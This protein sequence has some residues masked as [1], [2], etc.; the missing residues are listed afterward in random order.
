[1]VVLVIFSALATIR[2]EEAE[3][4]HVTTVMLCARVTRVI[5]SLV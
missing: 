5:E 4:L 3:A 1:M 2:G